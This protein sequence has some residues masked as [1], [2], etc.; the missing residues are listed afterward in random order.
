MRQDTAARGQGAGTHREIFGMEVTPIHVLLVEDDEDD[1][2]I[3][4][5]LLSKGGA[6][7]FSLKW[8]QSVSSAAAA[9]ADGGIDVVLLDLSLPDSQGWN[10]FQAVHAMDRTLP[11]ILLTG[12]ADE[13]LSIKAVQ[14]GAQDYLVKG[15]VDSETLAR[16]IRYAI[17]RKLSEEAMKRYRDHLEELVRRRTERIRLANKELQREVATRKEVER[18]IETTKNYLETIISA[19]HDGILLIDSDG[20]FEFGNEA[21]CTIL[22]WPWDLLYKQPFMKVFPEDQHDFIRERWGEVKKGIERPYEADVITR[23]G[24]R[25]SL[26]L[27]HRQTWFADEAKYCVAIKDVTERKRAEQDLRR[28]LRRLEEHDR[29]KTEFVSNVSHELKTPLASMSYAL[30]NLLRG[31]VAEVDP[32]VR[33]YLKMMRE[34]CRRLTATVSDILDLSRLEARKLVLNRVRLHAGRFIMRTIESLRLQAEQADLTLD[35]EVDGVTVFAEVD[36]QK[37]E[38]VVLNIVNN[39]IK[40][41]PEGGAIHVELIQEGQ[42]DVSTLLLRVKDTGIGIPEEYLKRVTERYFRVGD[43]VTGSGL[44]LAISKELIEL[45]GGTLEVDSPPPGAESGTEVRIRIPSARA[46]SVLIVHHDPARRELISAELCGLG[47]RCAACEAGDEAFGVLEEI[48]ADVVVLDMS[49]PMADGI[50]TIARIKSSRRWKDLALVAIT[51]GNSDATRR[52]IIEGFSIPTVDER[53]SVAELLSKAEGAVIA[54][55]K[56]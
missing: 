14:K 3:T 30:D 11:V 54:R 6:S 5:D 36:A 52:E 9:L 19:S 13:T 50:G 42:G 39:A 23:D 25:R 12:F 29:A 2:I 10:T 55:H 21:V 8:A 32:K 31:I 27:S 51:N 41:T 48:A 26:L 37:F 34:D 49:L 47:Y 24:L 20:Q 53:D 44:G 4:R 38:R 22:G 28:T 45:H 35:V 33:A 56:N 46:T 7:T 18:E 15:D 1:Y 40:F 16:S 17:E 43:H